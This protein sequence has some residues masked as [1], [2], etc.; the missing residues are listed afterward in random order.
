MI[1]IVYEFSSVHNRQAMK[2]GPLFYEKNSSHWST[3]FAVG[4]KEWLSRLTGNDEALDDHIKPADERALA[5]AEHGIWFLR[6]SRAVGN[7]F[8]RSLTADHR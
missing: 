4:G 1:N 7:R 6:P 2:H 5:D 3:A 8:R